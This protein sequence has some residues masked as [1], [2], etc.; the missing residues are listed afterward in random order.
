MNFEL[1]FKIH[2]LHIRPEGFCPLDFQLGESAWLLAL[3]L[4]KMAS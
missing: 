2:S 3:S 1:E 4:V